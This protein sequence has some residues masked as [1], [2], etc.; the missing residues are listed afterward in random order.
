MACNDSAVREF[1]I[2]TSADHGWPAFHRDRMAE[3][4]QP[5]GWG[6]PVSGR[7]TSA[8]SRASFGA[9]SAWSRSGTV[10]MP[11]GHPPAGGR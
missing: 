7:T 11:D 6:M 10:S 9:S 8:P 2:R 1:L 4:L 3:V 5:G